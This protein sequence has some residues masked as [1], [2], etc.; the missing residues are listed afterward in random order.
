MIK[1][2][3][4]EELKK[5]PS[6]IKGDIKK[7]TDHYI[8][9]PNKS[10]LL[11]KRDNPIE[12]VWHNQG[13]WQKTNKYRYFI[14]LSIFTW[15]KILIGGKKPTRTSGENL[16]RS[17]CAGKFPFP[18]SKAEKSREEKKKEKSFEI[19]YRGGRIEKKNRREKNARLLDQLFIICKIWEQRKSV[20]KKKERKERRKWSLWENEAM[21][22]RGGEE[23]RR[24]RRNGPNW[25]GSVTKKVCRASKTST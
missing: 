23:R 13:F 25:R 9:F 8:S 6:N 20:K 11:T 17:R 21:G 5:K 12:K 14:S 19:L 16:R 22:K 10:I 1:L 3:L 24:N 7:N 2:D 18:D 15:I 4:K